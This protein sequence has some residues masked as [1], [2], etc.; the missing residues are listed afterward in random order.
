MASRFSDTFIKFGDLYVGYWDT[1][2]KEGGYTAKRLDEKGVSPCID[3]TT[4]LGRMPAP[5]LT[6]G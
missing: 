4:D 1:V 5:R 3:T 6:A 2:A